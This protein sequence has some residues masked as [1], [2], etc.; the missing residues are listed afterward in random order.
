MD[1]FNLL[2]R[3]QNEF[4]DLLQKRSYLSGEFVPRELSK[5][6]IRRLRLQ[7]NEIMLK[8]ERECTYYIPIKN[9][10]KY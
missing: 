2:I 9:L 7:I 10:I 6:K 4:I 5:A 1:D 3:L 8:I